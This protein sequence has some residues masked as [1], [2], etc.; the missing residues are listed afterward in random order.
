MKIRWL[1]LE[2][3]K[4]VH[5]HFAN[6]AEQGADETSLIYSDVDCMGLKQNMSYSAQICIN[7]LGS[8]WI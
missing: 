8:K 2:Q 6:G 3:I 4:I 5:I 1:G 7:V